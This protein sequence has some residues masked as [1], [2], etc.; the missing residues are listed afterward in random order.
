MKATSTTLESSRDAAYD[1]VSTVVESL[2]ASVM[3]AIVKKTCGNRR[4]QAAR[5][6]L[7]VLPI[8]Q[9]GRPAG[10]RFLLTGFR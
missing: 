1:A 10:R 9:Q 7:L 5:T 2:E 4:T 6:T 8:Q 3:G